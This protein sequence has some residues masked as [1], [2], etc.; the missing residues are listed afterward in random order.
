MRY[1]IVRGIANANMLMGSPDGVM[2]AAATKM[3]MTAYRH[4]L[5]RALGDTT[6]TSCKKTRRTGL[7]KPMPNASIIITTRFMYFVT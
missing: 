7:R 2:T 3:P 5:I 1:K 4:C 6:D